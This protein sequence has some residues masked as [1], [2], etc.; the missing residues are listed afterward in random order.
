MNNYEHYGRARRGDRGVPRF[1]LQSENDDKRKP[2]TPPEHEG[3]REVE[4]WPPGTDR[5]SS[6]QPAEHPPR[7]VPFAPS[8]REIP[9][10]LPHEPGLD[11]ERASHERALQP[12]P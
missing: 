3:P 10:P 6:D 8:R 1:F 5:P 4:V 2:R 12:N 9:E 7:E 11:R